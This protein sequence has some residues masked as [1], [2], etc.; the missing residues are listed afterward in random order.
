MFNFFRGGAKSAPKSESQR[1]RFKRLVREL[2]EM[3][4]AMPTKPRVMID[5][6]TGRIVPEVPDQFQD[7]ALALPKPDAATAPEAKPDAKTELKPNVPQPR[8]PAARVPEPRVG[9]PR[10]GAAKENEEA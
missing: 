5:L 2:N 10:V 9:Q 8:V 1:D 3:I 4:D 6:E 7:E